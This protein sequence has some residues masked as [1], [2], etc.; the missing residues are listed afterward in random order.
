MAILGLGRLDYKKF[1]AREVSGNPQFGQM[2]KQ[3][4]LNECLIMGDVSVTVIVEGKDHYDELLANYSSPEFFAIKEGSDLNNVMTLGDSRMSLL[5]LSQDLDKKRNDGLFSYVKRP[6]R[7][8][9]GI[10]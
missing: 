4:G 10:R 3:L 9:E 1:G 6:R 7:G 5:Q 8:V 2:V